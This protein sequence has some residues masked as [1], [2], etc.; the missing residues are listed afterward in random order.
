MALQ[1]A[2]RNLR[3]NEAARAVDRGLV[4]DEATGRPATWMPSPLVIPVADSLRDFFGS[5]EFEAKVKAA[6]LEYRFRLTPSNA[7]G[8]RSPLGVRPGNPEK[9]DQ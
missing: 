3:L 1:H 6:Q 5:R 2:V 8:G 4:L 7:G 9:S